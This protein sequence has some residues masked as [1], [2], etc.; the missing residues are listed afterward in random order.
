MKKDI[1][2]KI[3]L[4]IKKVFMCVGLFLIMGSWFTFHSYMVQL[5]YLILCLIVSSTF[6]FG[7]KNNHMIHN[8][9]N[10]IWK[11]AVVEVGLLILTLLLHY[12][13]GYFDCMGENVTETKFF[14]DK[15]I[16]VIVPHQDDDI[17]LM[18]GVIEKYINEGSEVRVV[19]ATNG[20]YYGIGE[21][22]L[23]EAVCALT[24]IGIK[25][26]N[27]FFLGYGSMWEPMVMPD[28]KTVNHIYNGVED[29]VVWTS[30][31]K[32]RETYG[33]D[34][35]LPYRLS[36]YTRSNFVNSIKEIILEYHPEVIYV[37][38]YDTHA[39]HRATSLLFEEAMGS[40]LSEETGY[41]PIVLKGCCYET[42]WHT[43]D[44]FLSENINATLKGDILWDSIYVWENRIRIPI[45]SSAG[46]Q[47]ISQNSV[48]RA[49]SQY[50]SQQAVKRAGNII[51]GDKVFGRRRTDSI[52]YS[53]KITYGDDVVSKLN[54][55]KLID[56]YDIS[57]MKINIPQDGIV[58]IERNKPIIVQL[59][60]RKDIKEI[61]LYDN[62]DCESNILGGYIL[63]DS[64]QKVCFGSLEEA[65]S[66]T[67]VECNVK[68]VNEFRIV[69]T[70]SKG[71]TP[72]LTEIEAYQNIQ[73]EMDRYIKITDD[74]DN[75][76]YNYLLE[77]GNEQKFSLYSS[78]GD[79]IL[80]D[81][82]IK[83]RGDKECRY[84]L[85]NNYISV[86]CP[87]GKKCKLTV[88]LGEISDE[89]VISNPNMMQRNFLMCI[90]KF[91]YY[92]STY[93]NFF[94]EKYAYYRRLY[95][96]LLYEKKDK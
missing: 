30:H 19:F 91:D 17:N 2:G 10:L 57:D 68:N 20:D 88:T 35:H 13:I 7:F 47:I 87:K 16:M 56:S 34:D 73:E 38:D 62:P 55:F 72:G 49:L 4:I 22:R 24:Q 43:A 90:K 59:E 82:D 48:Y 58:T 45:D 60:S 3:L 85:K 29:N 77:K 11:I 53:A 44:D 89:I 6:S 79:I 14:S 74:R 95:I 1:S 80:K 26:E 39:D 21:L 8:L 51:N 25:E 27:I 50:A 28:G 84:E 76:C 54:D 31:D 66:E 75:F 46:C 9:V 92:Y 70:E 37:N 94:T 52:L 63:F 64:G 5:Y 78:Y 33:L 86:Y 93:N 36:L 42:A 69:I 32:K 41:M 40:I 23:E 96:H 12:C 67:R 83:I 81:C 15:N 61:Y 71:K 65:G 18:G